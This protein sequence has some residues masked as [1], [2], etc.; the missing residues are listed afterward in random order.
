MNI[1]MVTPM[2]TPPWPK[3]SVLADRMNALSV[4]VADVVA[5]RRHHDPEPDDP[6]RG[7]YVSDHEA[8]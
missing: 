5:A 3:D 8:N 2:V 4:R 1:P 7:M 6:Y